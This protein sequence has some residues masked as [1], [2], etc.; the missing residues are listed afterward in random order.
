MLYRLF[1]SLFLVQI[2]SISAAVAA[3]CSAD[4][5]DEIRDEA[6]SENPWVRIDCDVD[7]TPDDVITK[8]LE[9]RGEGA[10]GVTLDCHGALIDG[11]RK[12]SLNHRKDMILI[13]SIALNEKEWSAPS[14]ITVSEC[15]VNGSVRLLGMAK[16][17]EKYNR[18]SWCEGY[19]EEDPDCQFHT[20]RAQAAAPT[21]IRLTGLKVTGQGRVPVYFSAGVTDSVIEESEL[22]G[23][24]DAVGMYLDAES[25]RNTVRNNYFH[26][27]TK[28][29]SSTPQLAIDGSAHNLIVGNRFSAIDHGGIWM[30]RNCGERGTV[31]HQPPQ[32]NRIINNTFYYNRYEGSNPA[33]WLGSRMGERNY[34]GLDK[35]HDFGSGAS[36]LDFARYNV[37]GQNRIIKRGLNMIRFSDEPNHFYANSS[38]D[39]APPR[40]SGCYDFDALPRA[41]LTN[42]EYSERWD[43]TPGFCRPTRKQCL[44]GV[45]VESPGTCPS[46]TL[47]RQ[48]FTCSVDS[49][50]NNGTACSI[51]CPA[52]QSIFAA[53]AVC[54]LEMEK[55]D[56]NRLARQGWH[57]LTVTRTSD[58]LPDGNCA[59][60][61]TSVQRNANSIG[62]LSGLQQSI[63]RCSEHDQN[64]GDCA[65]SGEYICAGP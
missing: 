28:D 35:E 13:R 31:R 45:L 27:D 63:V 11:G 18:S 61:T 20:A 42:G 25:A 12:G 16:D 37:V 19:E 17:L 21:N 14:G 8:R 60:H 2:I 62:F 65:I 49:S 15:N 44:D 10:S 57:T 3:P 36:D 33:I 58:H 55:T 23:V 34:C 6:T 38:V 22:A 4:K 51:G 29:G 32:Y 39:S 43:E 41:W 59:I 7:L 30:Y 1:I 24:S 47:T 54:N 26:V 50:P 64:G 9:F 52:G 53:R 5:M 48:Q 46:G 56:W 40:P